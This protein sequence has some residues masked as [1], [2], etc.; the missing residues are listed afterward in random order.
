M[1]IRLSGCTSKQETG[2]FHFSTLKADFKMLTLLKSFYYDVIIVLA[3]L[4]ALP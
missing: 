3:L 4:A 1:I 2:D